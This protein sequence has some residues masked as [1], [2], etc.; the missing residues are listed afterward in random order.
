MSLAEWDKVKLKMSFFIMQF[1]HILVL[2]MSIGCYKD[3]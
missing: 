3:K 2:L 1:T